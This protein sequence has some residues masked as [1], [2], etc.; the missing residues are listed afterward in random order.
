MIFR[1]AILAISLFLLNP[2]L[3]Q[4]ED[5]KKI[6]NTEFEHFFDTKDFNWKLVEKSFNKMLKNNGYKLKKKSKGNTYHNYLHSFVSDLSEPIERTEKTDILVSEFEKL[7]PIYP[8]FEDDRFLDPWW[9]AV[10]SKSTIRN[11]SLI[12]TGDDKLFLNQLKNQ[13]ILERVSV[14]NTA[15]L[16]KKHFSRLDLSVPVY[17]KIMI[18]LIYYQIL[19]SERKEKEKEAE[20]ELE[21][22]FDTWLE[23]KNVEWPSLK[24]TFDLHM[25]DC[26]TDLSG[27]NDRWDYLTFFKQIA[28]Q[29]KINKIPIQ[30]DWCIRFSN[31]KKL[32]TDLYIITHAVY[33]EYEEYLHSYHPI[34]GLN[35]ILETMIKEP[36]LSIR[37]LA[38]GLKINYHEGD[39]KQAVHQKFF[40]SILLPYFI[41]GWNMEVERYPLEEEVGI[42]KEVGAVLDMVEEMPEFPGGQN[43]M[44]QFLSSN[45][46][47]PAIAKEVGISGKV[48]VSFLVEKDGSLT[49]I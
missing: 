13:F 43:A 27:N 28:D 31:K 10:I 12:K 22:R 6:L 16:L 5:D 3:S 37:V 20:E 26:F 48:Y 23:S 38:D 9:Y 35:G 34:V 40:M 4:S 8:E 7:G 1:I 47:Y 42:Q 41:S 17:Q 14:K 49:N 19:P 30:P 11:K 25:I 32:Y 18:C 39:V 33:L 36:D 24:S 29:D 46:K 21:I 45:I 15:F 2:V 44:N